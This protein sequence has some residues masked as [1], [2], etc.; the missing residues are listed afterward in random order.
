MAVDKP[1]EISQMGRH[2]W[3]AEPSSATVA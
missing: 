3:V 2:A 1:A